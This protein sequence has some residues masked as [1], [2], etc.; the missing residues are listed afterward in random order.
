MVKTWLN[1][2]RD[3]RPSNSIDAERVGPDPSLRSRFSLFLRSLPFHPSSS[4]DLF[5]FLLLRF[6]V[7]NSCSVVLF[8]RFEICS[9]CLMQRC[10][11]NFS[12]RGSSRGKK[13]SSYLLWAAPAA[14]L[15]VVPVVLVYYY[16][17]NCGTSEVQF[18]LFCSLIF[19]FT[20]YVLHVFACFEFLYFTAWRTCR[21]P[22]F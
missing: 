17:N 16:Q 19:T 2:N 13:S 6:I 18:Q 21:R 5:G 1:I 10:K 15:T 8:F 12:Q 9:W 11:I 3:C 20:Y 22:C 14:I 7:R 4:S